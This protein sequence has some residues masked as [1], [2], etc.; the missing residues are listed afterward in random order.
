MQVG[1]VWR[2]CPFDFAQGRLS[3]A[4]SIPKPAMS[5]AKQVPAVVSQSQ[6]SDSDD[7]EPAHPKRI[8]YLH[9]TLSCDPLDTLF[10]PCSVPRKASAEKSQRRAGT[11]S[12]RI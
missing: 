3:P 10:Q 7:H 1:T 8:V 12:H 6:F 5:Y 4:N 2:G 11:C 9:G